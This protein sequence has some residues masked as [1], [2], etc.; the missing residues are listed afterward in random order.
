M[1]LWNFP[2]CD[3]ILVCKMRRDHDRH[4]RLYEK[5]VN[6]SRVPIPMRSLSLV[7]RPDR[8]MLTAD[9]K[10]RRLADACANWNGVDWIVATGSV[11]SGKTSWLTALL[12]E[13]MWRNPD[14]DTRWTSEHRLYRKA[15][16]HGDKSPAGRER[17]LQE[18][19]DAEILVMD[20]LGASRRALTEWQ[21]GAM[22]DL[23]IERH[24]NGLPTLIT[25]NLDLDEVASR[26]GDHVASRLGEVSG[27]IIQIGGRDRR[28]GRSR[29]SRQ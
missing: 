25:T 12:L 26:Y 3:E 27:G 20:D 14:L 9:K 16:L 18:F 4:L 17:V 28:S 15:M 10:N 8:M 1:E 24:L 5:A 29:N 19:M 22:R 21:G 13:S 2:S 11:G 23:L 6:R 7:K